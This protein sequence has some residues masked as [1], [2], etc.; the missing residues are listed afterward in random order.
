MVAMQ[1]IVGARNTMNICKQL[2]VLLNFLSGSD[3]IFARVS[4][5]GCYLK[6]MLLTILL[7]AP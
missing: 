4:E 3:V 7:N 6:Q 5:G 1:D 2:S